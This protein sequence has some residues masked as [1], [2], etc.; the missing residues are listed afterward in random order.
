MK[1]MSKNR[2]I[3]IAGLVLAVCIAGGAVAAQMWIAMQVQNQFSLASNKL[4]WAGYVDQEEDGTHELDLAQ[5]VAAG[6]S[7]SGDSVTFTTLMYYY[8]IEV[9][10]SKV[11]SLHIRLAYQ[12][13]DIN[14]VWSGVDNPAADGSLE[15]FE[16][17]AEYYGQIS[18]K[19]MVGYFNSTGDWVLTY[20][21]N[22]AGSTTV[23]TDIMLSFTYLWSGTAV[24]LQFSVS[25]EAGS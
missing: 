5:F 13:E 14:L 9:T 20:D 17:Y 11:V 10:Y 19:Q 8:D 15:Y 18:S 4:M 25:A 12:D 6:G 7:I 24:P 3:A 16:V 23:F 22:F 21:F 1:R 2:K